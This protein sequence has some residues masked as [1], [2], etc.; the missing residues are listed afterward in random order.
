MPGLDRIWE[1]LRQTGTTRHAQLILKHNACNTESLVGLS[2]SLIEDGMPKGDLELIL[3]WL[4]PAPSKPITGRSDHPV[5]WQPE[6]LAGSRASFTL[7]LQAAEPNQRKRSLEELERD[8]LAQSTRPSQESRV[9]T[10][11][12]ICTA[13]EVVPFP[14][15]PEC[16]KAVGA[17]LKAGTGRH[18]C[19]FRL[20]STTR[21]GDMVLLWSP[22]FELSSRTSIDP[23]TFESWL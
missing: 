2:R 8:V 4:T 7:A 13:W 23:S 16:V 9:R 1:A 18:T 21:L 17:S 22:S 10:F 12:A 3:A 11:L 5:L 19:T 14:L 6:S 20:L 15:T